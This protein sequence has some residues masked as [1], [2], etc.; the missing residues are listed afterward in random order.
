VRVRVKI[1][2]ITTREAL[3]AAVDAGADAVGFVFADSPRRIEP[4]AARE[5]AAGL[6][7]FVTTVAVFRH[8]DPR[9]V[10]EIVR[11]LRPGVVQCEPAAGLV[12]ALGPG[13]RFLPVLHDGDGVEA[14]AAA[15]Q[16]DTVLLEA[17]GR[18]GRGVA[19]DRERAARLAARMRLVLAGGLTAENVGDAI[20]GVRPFAV[21]VSSG[22]ERAPGLKDPDMI[23]R[24]LEAASATEAR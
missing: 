11:L 19:P 20:R 14:Q 4:G 9:E 12:E 24:F 22:V 2:G 5:L 7:P 15:V 17:A 10:Q 1:C 23:R 21:D 3:L 18:G 6:S 8:P 16:A 13:V